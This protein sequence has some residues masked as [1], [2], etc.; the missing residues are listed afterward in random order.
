MLLDD[1]SRQKL[2]TQLTFLRLDAVETRLVLLGS[3]NPVS[4]RQKDV[5]GA[6]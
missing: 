5:S 2:D 4:S 3:Q 6:G 1:D